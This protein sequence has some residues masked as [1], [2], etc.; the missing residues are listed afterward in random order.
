MKTSPEIVKAYLERDESAF[1][2]FDSIVRSDPEA[3]EDVAALV[4]ACETDEDLAYVAAGPLEDLLSNFPMEVK[5]PL[6]KQVRKS[7][8][9]RKAVQ[10]AF[11]SEGSTPRKVLD[12]ILQKYGLTYGSL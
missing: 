2:H 1:A 11:A 7:P 12:E 3:I 9:M 8:K 4:E 10:G 5:E 6:D